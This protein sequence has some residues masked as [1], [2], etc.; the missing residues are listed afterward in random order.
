MQKL[1]FHMFVRKPEVLT[2]HQG[3]T[4]LVYWYIHWYISQWCK[5]LY[6]PLLRK[7]CN[8]MLVT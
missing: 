3:Y 1:S 2:F 8:Q 4:L 6:V 7:I 5:C